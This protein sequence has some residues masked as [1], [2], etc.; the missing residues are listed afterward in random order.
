V[1]VVNTCKKLDECKCRDKKTKMEPYLKQNNVNLVIKFSFVN[2][3][4]FSSGAM[5]GFFDLSRLKA[6]IWSCKYA[7]GCGRL[8]V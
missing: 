3:L 1:S 6:T 8:S 7:W 2:L 4:W 5:S